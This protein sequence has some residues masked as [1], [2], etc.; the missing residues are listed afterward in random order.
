MKRTALYTLSALTAAI[1]LLP[2]CTSDNNIHIEGKFKGLKQGQFYAY[3]YSPE[4]DNYDTILVNNGKFEFSK[5]TSDTTIIILQYPNFMETMIVGIP[6]KTIKLKGDA[7][8]LNRIN[9]SGSEENELISDFQKDVFK[10]S[11]SEKARMAERFIKNHP[12]SYASLVIFQKYLL[13]TKDLNYGKLESLLNLMLK[14]TPDRTHLLALS[15]QI[16]PYTQ[17]R[18]GKKIPRFN[19]I[20]LKKESVNNNTFKSKLT[21]ISFWATW[22]RDYVRPLALASKTIRA[23][24]G[25]IEALNICLDTDTTGCLSTIERDSIEGYNICDQQAWESP[26]VKTFGIRYM[27][28]NILVDKNGVILSRDIPEEDIKDTLKKYIK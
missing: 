26:L 2:A 18:P 10:K 16:K 25:K 4:W 15:A 20:T 3:S 22:S 27:P 13:D 24:K 7:R 6:G 28:S 19:A 14:A 17:C 8:D 21:L 11:D 23:N 12:E 9:L 5:E 1:F